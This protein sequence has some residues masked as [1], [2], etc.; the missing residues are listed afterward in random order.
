VRS[1]HFRL[2]GTWW[3]VSGLILGHGCV[4]AVWIFVFWFLQREIMV[5]WGG[6]VPLIFGALP[7]EYLFQGLDLTIL[8]VLFYS[9]VAS[10]T[11]EFRL[12]RDRRNP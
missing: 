8:T 11:Q 9:T 3:R 5:L 6:D 1:G 10:S 12:A 2:M 4:A 7:L